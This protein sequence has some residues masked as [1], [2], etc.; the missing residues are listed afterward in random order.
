MIGYSVSH[1]ET[2]TETNL[3]LFV[4]CKHSFE[5]VTIALIQ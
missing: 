2:L 4:Q 5:R 3:L 1:V